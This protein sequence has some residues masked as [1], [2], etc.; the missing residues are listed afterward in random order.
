MISFRP[1]VPVALGT[2]ALASVENKP[3]V[4]LVRGGRSSTRTHTLER[5][6]SLPMLVLPNSPALRGRDTKNPLGRMPCRRVLFQGVA[7]ISAVIC[8][9]VY[10]LS[11]FG[12]PTVDLLLP[13]CAV[14][15]GVSGRNLGN[16]FALGSPWMGSLCIVRVSCAVGG[17]RG[18]V[19]AS[20]PVFP[21]Q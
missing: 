6:L 9:T 1:P 4:P 8:R 12:I 21:L 10:W 7:G 16:G 14:S 13:I 2:K 15:A 17:S 5:G 18:I 19:P 11:L 20:V 3:T